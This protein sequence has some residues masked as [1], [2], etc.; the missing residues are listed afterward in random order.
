MER[1]ASRGANVSDVGYSFKTIYRLRKTD[2]YSSVFSF[3]KSIRGKYFV[4]HFRPA[5]D[6]ARLGLVIGKKLA[7]QSVLRNLLKR[8]T[9]EHF[10][11]VRENLPA[12]DVVV[13]L[14]SPVKGVSRALI[15]EDLSFIFK[16]LCR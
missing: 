9:R 1:Q 7:R 13:R 14:A 6:S 15:R 8:L 4:L 5:G 16:R 10:R 12:C 2:E 11:Q 3:R